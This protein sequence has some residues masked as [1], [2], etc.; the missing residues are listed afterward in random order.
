MLGVDGRSGVPEKLLTLKP[1]AWLGLVS[2]GVFLW[3]H[4]LTGKFRSV[5]DWTTH[6][7]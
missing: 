1:V 6:G 2:Y 7:S 3:H 5:Q 4:P